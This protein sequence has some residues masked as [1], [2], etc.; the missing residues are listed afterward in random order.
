M[1]KT[2]YFYELVIFWGD[3]EINCDFSG[4]VKWF[5]QTNYDG[6]LLMKKMISLPITQHKVAVVNRYI[7]YLTLS[8]LAHI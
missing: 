8:C 2:I 5:R 3:S 6:F 1:R 7:Y 4:S